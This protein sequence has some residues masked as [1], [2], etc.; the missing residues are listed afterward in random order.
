M[1]ASD[2][3][4]HN[5]ITYS[6]QYYAVGRFAVLNRMHR[7]APNLLHHAVEL[8]LKAS[9]VHHQSLKF[10]KNQYG[11]DLEKLWAATIAKTPTLSSPHR[12]QTISDLAQFEELRYPDLLMTQGA[13]V[14][15][16][17]DTG[18][19]VSTSGSPSSTITEPLYQL[20]LQDIDE[21]W[22]ALFYHADGKP[23][24]FLQHLSEEARAVLQF[25]NRHP[26]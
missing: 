23:E 1:T 7:I 6:I 9:L 15:F 21:L 8:V 11:H 26:I 12:Q 17:M 24:A 19:R 2:R 22:A 14:A 20:N 18:D 16:S 25:N 13:T 3:A 4:S 5:L 10:L